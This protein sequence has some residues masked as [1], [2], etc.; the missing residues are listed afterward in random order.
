MYMLFV[1]VY[2][3]WDQYTTISFTLLS[4]TF[5]YEQKSPV[6]RAPVTSNPASGHV[7]RH[8]QPHVGAELA[9][10]GHAPLAVTIGALPR[11]AIA[12]L[13]PLRPPNLT[14]PPRPPPP[15]T[16]I[17]FHIPLARALYRRA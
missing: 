16:L 14:C 7:A 11:Q 3:L 2:A 6:D 8:G 17:F 4:N 13:P 10:A 9:V 5:S 12:I 1:Y 15:V